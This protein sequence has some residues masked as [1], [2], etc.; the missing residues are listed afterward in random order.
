MAVK[1]AEITAPKH[2]RAATRRWFEATAIEFELEEHHL[3]LLTLASENWDRCC[4]ARESLKTSGMTY[5]DRFGQPRSRP[6]IAILRDCTI[7]FA[8]LMRELDLD[9][10]ENPDK[11]DKPAKGR[12]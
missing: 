4:E 6:E 10:E 8:R 5:T 1:K 3:K 2:L 7:A 12:R 11:P 9:E